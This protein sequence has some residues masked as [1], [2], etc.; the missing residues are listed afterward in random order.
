MFAPL[1]V[2]LVVVILSCANAA[3]NTT[4]SGLPTVATL[5]IPQYLG[6]WYQV[7]AD[8]AVVASFEKGTQCATAKYGDNGDGTISVHNYAT[9]TDSGAIYT[10]DGYAYQKDAS[11]PGKLM[12]HFSSSD[13]FPF[14]APY[15]VVSL[16]PV[17][18][19]QYDYAIVT[20]NFSAYLF[21]LARDVSTYYSKYDADVQKQLAAFGFSGLTKPI[22]TYHGADCVYE[23]TTRKA[24][25]FATEQKRIAAEKAKK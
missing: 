11:A 8:P 5:N 22:K 7:Y 14:D 4:K 24:E 21:V 10:I 20:D 6:L 19:N 1:F 15:W 3:L 16:G 13:A 2:L 23:S 17:V 18:N 25:M 9:Y 12:V